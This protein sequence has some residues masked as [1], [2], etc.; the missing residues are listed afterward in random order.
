PLLT[1][2]HTQR[3]GVQRTPAAGTNVP[4]RRDCA[5]QHKRAARSDRWVR[6]VVQHTRPSWLST[7]CRTTAPRGSPVAEDQQVGFVP[8]E[9][10]GVVA[11]LPDPLSRNDGL[12]VAG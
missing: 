12:A 11:H 9:A 10:Q 5:A 6:S 3:T 1:D 7:I 2:S 8:V 4:R